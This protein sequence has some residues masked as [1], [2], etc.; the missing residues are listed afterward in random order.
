MINDWLAS[1]TNNKINKV[2]DDRLNPSSHLVGVNTVYFKGQWMEP[3]FTGF[4]HEADFK[5]TQEETIR[6]LMMTGN[7]DVGYVE[8]ADLGCKMIS[9][10]YKVNNN[11]LE[12][13]NWVEFSNE[14]VN[15]TPIWPCTWCCQLNP[16]G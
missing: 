2:V 4:T 10:P 5:V 11:F 3:F 15:R 13:E 1:Q 6:V 12:S 7:L 9:I 14:N 8:N 16:T